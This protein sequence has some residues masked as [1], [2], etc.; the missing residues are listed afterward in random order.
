M[1]QRMSK[2]L[3]AKLS[4]I[5][6]DLNT[7]ITRRS[8]TNPCSNFELNQINRVIYAC[9]A[10]LGVIHFNF[11]ALDEAQFRYQDNGGF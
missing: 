9:E 5:H 10:S 7:Y 6:A 8:D 3:I 2:E 11:E 4:E 1:V